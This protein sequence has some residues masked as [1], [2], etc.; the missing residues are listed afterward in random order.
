MASAKNRWTK[1]DSLRTGVL[2]RARQAAALTIPSILPEMGA[3][4][5]SDLPQPYQS[6]GARGVN[7]L[8][9]KL[10][11]ALLPPSTSHFR[12]SIDVDV[13]AELED[14]SG[15]EDALRKRENK[16]MKWIERSNLR[17]AMFNALKQL[18][19][20]GNALL[21]IPKKGKMRTFRLD[22]YVVVRDPSGDMVEMHIREEADPTTL[23]EKITEAC[24][25]NVSEDSEQTKSDTKNCEIYTTVKLRKGGKMVDYWQE[26]NLI[27]VPG[28]R[29][30]SKVEESPYVLMRWS[31]TDNES[32]GR[33]HVEEYI[34][35]LR[36][37]EGLSMSIVGFSAVAA[38]I[39]F[40][41]HPNSTTSIDDLEK[42]NT[43]DFITGALKD[44]EALQLD[45]FADFKVSQSCPS[46]SR[47][48][49]VTCV[50]SAVRYS[51][52]RRT[53]HC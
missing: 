20:T 5:N 6:L 50:S 38:K 10:L 47:R 43:G 26:I 39:V 1:L 14:K 11:L 36:S 42:A 22:Q 9:S 24:K 48:A 17:V 12:F 13:A 41:V 35:D 7:N 28:S 8:A 32:Y 46:G 51:P 19:V 44:I 45:K 27:E 40:L 16:V 3:D 15:A 49:S 2:A 4:E 53:C 31:A 29:G 23:S 25:V 30:Q 33:G 21:Y 52:R 18:I 37:L 34:G